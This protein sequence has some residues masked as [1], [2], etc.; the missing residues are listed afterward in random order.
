LVNDPIG[1]IKEAGTAVQDAKESMTR[2]LDQLVKHPIDSGKA[3]LDASIDTID[4]VTS[5]PEDA[6]KFIVVGPLVIA[7][8]GGVSGVIRRV[9]PDIPTPKSIVD[10]LDLSDV[11]ID[12]D[13]FV[14]DWP[15][16]PWDDAKPVRPKKGGDDRFTLS[17][18][19]SD[20]FE[21]T[22]SVDSGS[23]IR[24]DDSST[25]PMWLSPDSNSL[26]DWLK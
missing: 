11:D 15:V 20:V 3:I 6:G 22:D 12:R 9:R 24:P 1:K 10:N 8:P 18:T 25:N 19:K 21:S 5:N 4:K 7:A 16:I 17:G 13:E 2:Q 26:P 14:T 23:Q